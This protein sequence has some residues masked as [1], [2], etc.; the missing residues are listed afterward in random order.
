VSDDTTDAAA[1]LAGRLVAGFVAVDFADVVV[2]VGVLGTLVFG[3]VVFGAVVFG[4]VV[5]DAVDFDAVDFAGA[6]FAGADFAGADFAGADLAVDDFAVVALGA[7]GR[8]AG[9][10][11]PVS[12][13]GAV[14][15]RSARPS[16]AS[17]SNGSVFSGGCVAEVT[18][19][20]YQEGG[21]KL[22]LKR[23]TRRNTT[24]TYAVSFATK[25]QRGH[26][27]PAPQ[28]GR[29]DMLFLA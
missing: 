22:S 3:A 8:A 17:A 28:A 9:F 2:V 29:Q 27:C 26:A 11:T 13:A 21:Q 16:A 10:R 25:P 24:S 19:L 4:A 18:R 14:G 12:E 6:D 20:T 15:I 7:L 23:R 5:F 1:V